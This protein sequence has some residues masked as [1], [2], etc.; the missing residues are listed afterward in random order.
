MKKFFILGLALFAAAGC[1]VTLQMD[2]QTAAV[3]TLAT[4]ELIYVAKGKDK[5]PEETK[6]V[7]EFL[8]EQLTPYASRVFRSQSVVPFAYLSKV[9][10]AMQTGYVF[11]VETLQWEDH[12]TPWT[13]VR[14]KVKLKIIVV[15][16]RTQKILYQDTVYGRSTL[17]TMRNHQPDVVAEDLVKKLVADLFQ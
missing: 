8:A 16:A 11:Y 12:N 3:P 9:A 6:I 17:W 15:D 1:T 5:F 4:G 2:P 14:D 7:Q 10:D 13:T